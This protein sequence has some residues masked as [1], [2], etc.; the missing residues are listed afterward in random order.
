MPGDH[1]SRLPPVLGPNVLRETLPA[2]RRCVCACGAVT[3]FV[4]AYLYL[5]RQSYGTGQSIVVDGGAVLVYIASGREREK[6]HT[7]R[8]RHD[9][10]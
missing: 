5:M 3:C 1:V 8:Y 4:Q 6:T 7:L 9:V 10:G 2:D